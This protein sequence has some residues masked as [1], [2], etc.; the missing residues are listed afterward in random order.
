MQEQQLLALRDEQM[1]KRKGEKRIRQVFV[2]FHPFFSFYAINTHRLCFAK[3]NVQAAQKGSMA[4]EGQNAPS[5]SVGPGVQSTL[6][7]LLPQEHHNHEEYDQAN[8]NKLSRMTNHAG[9][10]HLIQLQPR[11]RCLGSTG[12]W[13]LQHFQALL[14]VHTGL[15]HLQQSRQWFVG[16]SG[17]WHL[18]QPQSLLEEHACLQHLIQLQAVQSY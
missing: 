5:Y 2:S 17:L 15:Q 10:Q 12:M 6:P 4:K 7:S 8:Q 3:T 16:H 9:L 13:H 14:E 1:L 11:P 18:R